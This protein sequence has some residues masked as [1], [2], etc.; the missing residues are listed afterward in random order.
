MHRTAATLA[1]LVA[2]LLGGEANAQYGNRSLGIGLGATKFLGA[3]REPIDW[4]VPFVVSGSLYLENSFET[5]IQA[6][7]MVVH[8]SYG[9]LEDGSGGLVFA[10]AGHVGVRYL[11][12]E[13]SVRPS[14][15]VH[16]AG[17]GVWPGPTAAAGLGAGGGVEFFVS[18]SVAIGARAFFDLFIV[19]LNVPLRFNL[20]GLLTVSTYF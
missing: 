3:E 16:L 14:L 8:R 5:F 2:F 7:V 20:G 1:L 19:D 4:G 17:M 10:L 11:F 6:H 12:A 13:E 18:D 9:A 15:D